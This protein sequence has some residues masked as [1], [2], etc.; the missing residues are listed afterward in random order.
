ML[1]PFDFKEPHCALCGG[2]E[3]YNPKSDDPTE[4]IPIK[5]IIDKLDGLFDKNDMESAGR[6]L[7]YWQSEAISLK[8]KEGELEIDSELIGFYRKTAKTEK[9]L[10][11]SERALE[12]VGALGL[13]N[14]VSAATVVLNAATT[15]KAFGLAEKALPLYDRVFAVYTANLKDD[16]PLFGGFYNNKALALTDLGRFSEAE[17][18]FK[19]A[20]AITEKISPANPDIAVTLVNLAHL[21]DA[22]GAQEKITDCLFDAFAVLN[23]DDAVKNGYYA[24]VCTKCAPSFA[25]FGYGVIE[26]Q[27]LA[28]AGEIYE[29]N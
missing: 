28:E 9:G 7:E 25:Y 14:S 17:E 12:L 6:L 8:D 4:R 29:R 24:F 27:L 5:R 15:F 26:K 2:K 20:L 13:E 16:D 1:D 22:S 18:C 19:K 21:Y 10:A 3:F 23:R 11:V